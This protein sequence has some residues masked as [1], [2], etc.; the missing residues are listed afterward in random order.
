MALEIGA[1]K[2]RN[3]E[4]DDPE[5]A[6]QGVP[7]IIV[8][9]EIGRSCLLGKLTRQ[10]FPQA[11]SY[12]VTKVLELIHGD[13]CGSITPT[14]LA[15][16]RYVFVIIDDCSRYMWTILL[17]EK[18]DAFAKFKKF[19]SLVEQ[20]SGLKIQTFRTDR[21]GEFVSQDFDSF[22]DTHGINGHL[23]ALYTPQQNGVVG[24]RNRTL[25][26]MARSIMKHMHVP[27]YLWGEAIRHST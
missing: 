3:N 20:E 16:N 4:V 6:C 25:M 19:K 7:S 15:G 13:L 2:C 9:K 5:R 22:C 14:T 8:E 24:K 26:G 11:T 10:V 27:N 17:K 23:T 12:R 1:H 21:G 18:S